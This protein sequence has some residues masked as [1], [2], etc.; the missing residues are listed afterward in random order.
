MGESGG[1]VFRGNIK[2]KLDITFWLEHKFLSREG[3]IDLLS[4]IDK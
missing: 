4:V 2:F 1:V 3:I